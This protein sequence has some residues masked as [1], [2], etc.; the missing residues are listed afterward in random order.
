[1]KILIAILSQDM[2]LDA[3]QTL[4][5]TQKGVSYQAIKSFVVNRYL[6]D[7]NNTTNSL[8][9]EGV[10][11]ALNN[12]KIQQK[13][14]NGAIGSFKIKEGNASRPKV[15][16]E[17]KKA[18]TKTKMAKADKENDAPEPKRRVMQQ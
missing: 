3:M 12:D 1:M 15:A 6:L 9:K 17:P 16:E 2:V 8:I 10:K 18:S 5:T 14:G 13:T 4:D 11:S 7:S